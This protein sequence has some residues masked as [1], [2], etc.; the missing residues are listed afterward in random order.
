MMDIATINVALNGVAES[1]N[2]SEV[3]P[4][5]IWQDHTPM[6]LRVSQRL[7]RVCFVRKPWKQAL[8]M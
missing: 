2:G 6:V 3:T 4:P 7:N 5:R 1:C 8:S